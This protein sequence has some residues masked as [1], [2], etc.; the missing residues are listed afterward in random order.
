MR[1]CR[2]G[3]GGSGG[4]EGTRERSVL[5]NLLCRLACSAGIGKKADRLA[6]A[7]ALRHCRNA[8]RVLYCTVN[9]W[10]W[11][12]TLFPPLSSCRASFPAGGRA[13]PHN[14]D[15]PKR[16]NFPPVKK[17]KRYMTA[18]ASHPAETALSPSPSPNRILY[19]AGSCTGL[20]LPPAPQSIATVH[21]I[22]VL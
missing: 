15:R 1:V 16:S 19:S 12:S 3:S 9:G 11:L 4:D 20:M 18:Q 13:T 10:G 2:G 7:A 17:G 22:N 8:F 21:I 6:E 5:V 14:S